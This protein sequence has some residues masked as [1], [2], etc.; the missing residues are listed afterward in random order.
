MRTEQVGHRR[1]S[2]YGQVGLTFSFRS[3]ELVSQHDKQTL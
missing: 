1:K 3:I 2:T